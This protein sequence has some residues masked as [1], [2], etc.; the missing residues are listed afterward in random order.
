VTVRLPL[1]F[2]FVSLLSSAAWSVLSPH[3][4]GPCHVGFF[5]QQGLFLHLRLL[6]KTTT[7]LLIHHHLHCHTQQPTPSPWLLLA[8][9]QTAPPHLTAFVWNC[10]S[11][12]I[13]LHW[14]LLT[15]Q[16][17]LTAWCAT[18]A[19]WLCSSAE[20][21]RTTSLFLNHLLRLFI[22]LRRHPSSRHFVSE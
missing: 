13:C 7:N 12:V 3:E 14:R 10:L 15:A 19:C 17:L 18:S 4:I 16:H 22:W 2:A 1:L 8:A 11:L 5:S 6:T 20:W 9:S 21:R